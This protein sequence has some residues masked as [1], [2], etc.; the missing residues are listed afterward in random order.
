MPPSNPCREFI[1]DS[2]SAFEKEFRESQHL[3]KKGDS[4]EKPDHESNHPDRILRD[5]ITTACSSYVNH[6]L[7]VPAVSFPSPLS[8]IIPRRFHVRF[9]MTSEYNIRV[10]DDEAG[11]IHGGER[12][13]K[14]EEYKPRC[15]IEN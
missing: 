3:S 1:A 10:I 4:A 9:S 15:N 12:Y 8:S 14:K 13:M 11:K 7:F 2:I 5:L 6:K